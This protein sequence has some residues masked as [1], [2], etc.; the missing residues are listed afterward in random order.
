MATKPILAELASRRGADSLL[1]QRRFSQIDF[2]AHILLSEGFAESGGDLY[3]LYNEMEDKDGH[4]FSV[5]QTR[6]N[7]VL[8]RERNLVPASE[9]DADLRIAD[10]VG[11]VLNSIPNFGQTLLNILDAIGKGFS[12]QEIIW[13]FAEDGSLRVAEIKSRFPGRFSFDADG[14]LRLMHLPGAQRL[15]ALSQT[16]G[17]FL[18]NGTPLPDRKFI[19]FTFG[20]QN[21]NP[22]GKG[23]LGRA[24]W[25]YWFKKNNLKFWA[26]YNEKF[27]APT[28]VAKYAHGTSEEERDRL[29]EV[30][31]SLQSDTG[32]VIP[33]SVALELLE[34]RAGE[35]AETF[36]N[37]GDYCNDEM[38]KIVLGE[39][40]TAS[41]GRRSGSL[42]LGRVHDQVRNEYIESDA[43][44][45]MA[46]INGQLIRW[47]VDFNF[48]INVPA[49]RWTI[50]T[51]ADDNLN[52]EIRIDRDLLSLGVPLSTQYFYQR[53]RGP[54][55]SEDE[56]P[57][58]YDDNN[59]F[60]YH[61]RYGVLTIN[62][63]RRSLG[64]P[65]VS[66]G[67]ERA[68]A[69]EAAPS[70]SDKTSPE[71]PPEGPL[72]IASARLESER[73]GHRTEA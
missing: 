4:L 73:E 14:R 37:L 60:Q 11:K 36:R 42:A 66:W 39:T 27:G 63:V 22:Y 38:S 72:E 10:A 67:H 32:V 31:E 8:A 43:R 12:V 23:L 71:D 13:R 17:G 7:G 69:R 28:A 24:Y 15:S 47:I 61:L 68:G 50:D 46:V 1:W 30:L 35:G 62:E 26:I 2:P 34:A 55:P 41:E 64:L 40:L 20:G 16:A 65:E 57:L 18:V 53:Y 45:L 33:E 19:V 9:N 25:Y 21:S 6:K 52:D 44:D 5:L 3:A 49:P 29:L 56:R 70:D 58:R 54:A 48:G 51:S 59:L